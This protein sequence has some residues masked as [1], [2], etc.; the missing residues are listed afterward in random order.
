[1]PCAAVTIF[2][3]FFD[4]LNRIQHLGLHSIAVCDEVRASDEA[5]VT[6]PGRRA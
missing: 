3:S 4:S 1:M 2:F 5:V 6:V